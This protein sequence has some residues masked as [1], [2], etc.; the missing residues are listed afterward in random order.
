MARSFAN[1][2][3]TITIDNPCLSKNEKPP[4]WCPVE[5]YLPEVLPDWMNQL[6]DQEVT[7]GG[8]NLLTYLGDPINAYGDSVSV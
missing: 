2:A 7:I 1:Q 8:D 4:T 5:K 6:S 3:F